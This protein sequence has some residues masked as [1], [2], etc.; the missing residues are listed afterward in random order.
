MH[1]GRLSYKSTLRNPF[2]LP[3]CQPPYHVPQK[4]GS[5]GMVTTETFPRLVSYLK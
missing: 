2:Y 5:K 4:P 1:P 3:T